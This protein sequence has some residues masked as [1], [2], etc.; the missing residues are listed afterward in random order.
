MIVQPPLPYSGNRSWTPG[1]G[2]HSRWRDLS[3]PHPGSA[4]RGAACADLGRQARLFGYLNWTPQPPQIPS[5]RRT[6]RRCVPDM[7][8]QRA[9]SHPPI[10]GDLVKASHMEAEFPPSL[11]MAGESVGAPDRV[12][13]IPGNHEPLCYRASPAI[14][15]PKPWDIYLD[16]DGSAR[17]RDVSSR[18]AGA[19]GP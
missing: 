11:G 18:C 12:T 3:D 1:D 8:A 6:R 2:G 13:V 14:T 4:A 17:W 16:G 15:S 7:Q 9:G 19:A 5:P 10:T